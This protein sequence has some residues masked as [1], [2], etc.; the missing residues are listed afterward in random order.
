MSLSV[1]VT[2]ALKLEL[3]VETNEP[4]GESKEHFCEWW[5]NIE[6]IFPRDVVCSK[7]SEVYFIEAVEGAP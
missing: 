3:A 1:T 6:I 5:V 4:T 2:D 7:L